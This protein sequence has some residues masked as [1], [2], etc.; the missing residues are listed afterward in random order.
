MQKVLQQRLFLTSRLDGCTSGVVIF[1]K[2]SAVSEA[3]NAAWRQKQ[4]Q[5]YY[6]VLSQQRVSLGLMEHSF[7]RK[8]KSHVD[9]KPTLLRNYSEELCVGVDEA[10]V[11]REWQRCAL[12]V[13]S[14][15]PLAGMDMHESDVELLTGRTHQVRLQFA[16]SSAPIHLDTRYTPVAGM[17]DEEDNDGSKL[18]GPEPKGP[19]G[20]HCASLEFEPNTVVLPSGIPLEKQ[21]SLTY[22]AST[23]WWSSSRVNLRC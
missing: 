6:K 10:D 3:F 13:H 5:K 15:T 4:V 2:S 1:A 7:R 20:L 21:F 8:S 22:K 16:A 9:A 17:L 23:P 11:A 14:C 12:T 18:F 19:I